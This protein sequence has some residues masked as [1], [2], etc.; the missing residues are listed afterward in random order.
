MPPEVA[1]WTAYWTGG[2]PVTPDV[3][4]YWVGG[5]IYPPT[6]PRILATTIIGGIIEVN[7]DNWTP[8][9]TFQF[10]VTMKYGGGAGK[11]Y[12][13]LWNKTDEVEVPNSEL[14]T[15]SLTYVRLTSPNLPLSGTKEYQL[16]VG[17][18]VGRTLTINLAKIKVKQAP[19]P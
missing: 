16:K 2:R 14:T 7:V 6:V 13:W 11:A 19:P 3:E 1:E 12:A 17:V 8:P 5:R 9:A 18:P 15:T 4:A 10:E